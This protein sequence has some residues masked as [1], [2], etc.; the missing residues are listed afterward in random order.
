[1]PG[2]IMPGGIMPGG[3]MPGGIM[4]GGIMPGGIMPGPKAA[5]PGPGMPGAKGIPGGDRMPPGGI[6]VWGGAAPGG[7]GKLAGIRPGPPFICTMLKGTLRDIIAA[8]AIA[9][10]GG[11]DVYGAII[12]TFSPWAPCTPGTGGGPWERP[13]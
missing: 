11:A 5:F 13:Q 4:P 9:L 1:M 8:A 6:I 10:P 2:G 7:A 12:G 3:I